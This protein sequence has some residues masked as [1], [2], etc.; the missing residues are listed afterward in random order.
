MR[1]NHSY[2]KLNRTASHRKAMLRNMVTSLF[3]EE[4][5]TTTTAKAK[6]AKRMAERMI[7]FARRGDLSARRQVAKKLKDPQV[8]RK[9]FDEIAPR[10]ADRPGGYT[11]V[12]K[13]TQRK[14]DSAETA[15]LELLGKDEKPRGK[16]KKPRKTYHEVDVPARP[17]K[18]K[19]QAAAP[20]EPAAA[21]EAEEAAGEAPVKE[22]K[23]APAQK[24]GKE[25]APREKAQPA[26]GEDTPAE[27]ETPEVEENEKEK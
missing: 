26:G 13:V 15:L 22:E 11:R 1:H 18:A 25:A 10:Y 5:I 7:T 8:L 27:N 3:A 16:K 9:L 14:G 17:Q 6:E 2:R 20:E 12:L 24:S 19:V 21:A 4:R 23:A